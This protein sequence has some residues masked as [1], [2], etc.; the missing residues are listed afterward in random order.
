M[1]LPLGGV[2]PERDSSVA[3][4]TLSC[5]RFFATLR[6]TRSE[7]LPQNDRKQRVQGFGLRSQS[8]F[9]VA[10][11]IPAL[12]VEDEPQPYKIA[13]SLTLLLCSGLRR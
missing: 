10:G 3:E 9:V 12:V 4:F 13:L 8:H 1:S 2:Y 7:G 5:M 11:F 6:M